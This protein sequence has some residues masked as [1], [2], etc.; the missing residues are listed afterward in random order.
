M[1]D[2]RRSPGALPLLVA[3]RGAADLAPEN[4]MAAFRLAAKHSADIVELDVYLSADGHAVVIHDSYLSRTTSG[5]GPVARMTLAELK[6]LD[7]GSW[8]DRRYAGAAAVRRAHD[9][10]APRFAG[11]P[12]PTLDEV[13]AWARQ[14]TPPTR[15]MIE[16]KGARPLFRRGL[17]ETCVRLVAA[18]EMAE[19]V[20]FISFYHPHLG[21]VKAVAPHIAVGTIVKQHLLDRVL[22]RW[23]ERR[24]EL[25]HNGLARWLLLR[26][27]RISQKVQADSLSIPA[28]ALT[29]TLV[30]A[31][32]AAGLAVS[33]GGMQWDYPWV[34]AL[35]ADTVS[36]EDPA[37]VRKVFLSFQ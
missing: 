5:L 16:L 29:R 20:I 12:I 24:P 10:A 7:A 32:H 23:L 19:R 9:A 26:P 28:S 11:E 1:L 18:Y 37:W 3:H 4:T 14:Q 17:A 22:T 35:G 27:L 33:P 13:L 30:E 25:E 15:L 6:T 8:F 2:L 34:I 31:A 21:R 36:T